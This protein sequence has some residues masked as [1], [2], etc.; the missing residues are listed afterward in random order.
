VGGRTS[1]STRPRR[2]FGHRFVIETPVPAL[3][4]HL[5]ALYAGLSAADT[6]D[7][8]HRYAV[9]GPD[10]AGRWS[11]L[12]DGERVG[13]VVSTRSRAFG[14]L[15][16][17]INRGVIE[18]ADGLVLLHAGG[19]VVDGVRILLP[20][21]M[22]AGKSTLALGLLRRGASYLGDEA[23]GLD[24]EGGTHAYP[25]AVSIDP[26]SWPL[27]P[28]LAPELAPEVA[29]WQP[30][31]WQLPPAALGV[32][33]ALDPRPADLVVLPGYEA[34]A[35]TTVEPLVGGAALLAVAGCVFPTAR[36]R[37]SLLRILA[38]A[39]DGA[40]VVRVRSGHLE[41]SVDAVLGL[42]G[43]VASGAGRDPAGIAVTA[44]SPPRAPDDVAAQSPP[45]D[46]RAIVHRCVDVTPVE[47]HGAT[48]VHRGDDDELL[49][50]S[51]VAAM[52]WWATDGRR[53][54]EDIARLV[55]EATD[56]VLL[57]TE[58]RRL[59]A[60]ASVHDLLQDG[61]LRVG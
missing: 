8:P 41:A 32:G 24:L 42:V 12:R 39:L 59:A 13:D 14:L 7:D 1:G 44:P 5:D 55:V 45:V 6:G 36:S 26:G 61:V 19:V 46:P 20:G 52:V 51:P 15:L 16:W 22:E 56:H 3:T 48:V 28:D 33:V 10:A 38:R 34:G 40:V 4:R 30:A 23:I 31:Q 9:A 53:S 29:A 25:K 57:S 27:F 43:D 50:L 18:D 35:P 2:A 37:A 58:R 47:L 21:A 60:L 11:V 49:E 54:V 17:C